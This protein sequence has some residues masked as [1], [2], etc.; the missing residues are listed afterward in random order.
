MKKPL[1]IIVG[2]TAVGK[3]EISIEIAK[4]LDGEIISADSMQIYKY[5]N[6]GTA[7]PTKEEIQDI[8]HYLIDEVEPDQEFNVA[9]FQKKAF[10]YIDIILSKKKLPI[11]VGGTG[12][13]INSLIYPLNFTESVSDWEYRNKLNKVADEK[14]NIYLYNLLEKIDPESA[15]KIH[16][17]NRKRVIR[18]L[19][20]YKKSGKKMSHYKKEM[21]KKDSPFSFIMIGLNMDRQLLYEKINQRVDIMI[22]KGLI[23]EVRDL[24]NKGYDKNLISM[25]GLG[26]KEIIQYLEGRCTLEEAVYIIKRDTRRFAKRQLT[27]FRRDKRIYWFQVDKYSSKNLLIDEILQKI[28]SNLLDCEYNE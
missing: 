9:L 21:I 16:P 23:K 27:W 2:P 13:Y 18:A 22:E 14:G 12:L 1:I 24:L 17:N 5:M 4:R 20:V 28:H 6:I 19:E 25:Q 7:K 15:K 26:Y 8:P 11:I 3:T 10:E